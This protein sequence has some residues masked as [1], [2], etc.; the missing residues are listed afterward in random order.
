MKQFPVL[1]PFQIILCGMLAEKGNSVFL[2]LNDLLLTNSLELVTV[3]NI[4][5]I[6]Y[7]IYLMKK[8]FL[9]LNHSRGTRGTFVLEFY[10]YILTMPECYILSGLSPSVI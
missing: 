4:C 5:S 7:I 8:R 2:N 3:E 1:S 10:V 9:G 6:F